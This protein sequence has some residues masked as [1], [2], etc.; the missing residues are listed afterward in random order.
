MAVDDDFFDVVVHDDDNV[1]DDLYVFVDE[2]DDSFVDIVFLLID[3]MGKYI[4]W[5]TS[6]DYHQVVRLD[7]VEL[8]GV[9]AFDV[10]VALDED[11]VGNAAEVE[12]DEDVVD[13]DYHFHVVVKHDDV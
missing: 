10:E 8:N 5:D 13:K 4:L 12:L 3:K 1:G 9:D 6:G 11:V 7:A 2:L